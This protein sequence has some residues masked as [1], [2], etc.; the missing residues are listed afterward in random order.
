MNEQL[1]KASFLFFVLIFFG[2]LVFSEQKA[3]VTQKDAV[4]KMMDKNSQ[5]T[6][7]VQK[8]SQRRTSQ[9]ASS[10]Y[11]FSP[12]L[13]QGK[14]RLIQ[15]TKDMKL[16]SNNIAESRL[17]FINIDFQKRIFEEEGLE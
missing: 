7:A 10:S 13:I 9:K 14:K 16:E 17:F 4:E 2:Q 3:S 8:N 11:S 6:S 12:L 5:N 1:K 15:K